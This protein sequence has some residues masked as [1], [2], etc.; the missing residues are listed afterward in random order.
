MLNGMHGMQYDDGE[1]ML[2]KA[3]GLSCRMSEI[4]VEAWEQRSRSIC[5]GS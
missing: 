4:V 3:Y 1:R 2:E 5:K